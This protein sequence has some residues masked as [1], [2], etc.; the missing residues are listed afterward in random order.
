MPLD[1]FIPQLVHAEMWKEREKK[2]VAIAN[3]NRD[4]E[5]EIKKAGDRVKITGIG[6]INIFPYVKNNFGVPMPLQTLDDQ[7]TWLYITEAIAYNYAI[8]SIDKK[9]SHIDINPEAK[10]KAGLA[11]NDAADQFIFAKYVDAGA[12]VTNNGVTSQTVTSSLTES[13]Q[14]LFEN[15]VPKEEEI[16]IEVTPAIYM[17]MLKAKIILDTDNSGHI[18][19]G[20]SGKFLNCNVHMSNNIVVDQAGVHHCMMRTKKAISYA[21]QYVETEVYDL[22]GNGFGKAVKN[23]MLYGAK[24]VNPKE[25]VDLRFTPGQDV[26]I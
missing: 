3:C 5:G 8:D 22:A 15:H 13:L 17:M 19:N 11:Q 23:L 1:N 20:Y 24:T 6:N 9:Q 25:L 14:I 7:S 10:R 16:V 26:I 12:F 18:A 4:H 2:F 21:E